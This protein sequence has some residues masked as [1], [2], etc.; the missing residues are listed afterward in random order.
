MGALLQAAAELQG[1]HPEDGVPRSGQAQAHLTS[2]AGA[3][4]RGLQDAAQIGERAA[5][6]GA[7][8]TLTLPAEDGA[9]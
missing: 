7:A 9:A 2:R 3:D 4:A 1:I 6:G 8:F 5:E